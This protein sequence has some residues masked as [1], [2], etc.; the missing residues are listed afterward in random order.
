MVTQPVSGGSVVRV[1]KC[2]K[3][4]LTQCLFLSQT[5]LGDALVVF[6]YKGQLRCVPLRNLRIPSAAALLKDSDKSGGRGSPGMHERVF[7]ILSPC[8]PSAGL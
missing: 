8:S 6:L 1:W 4:S 3:K 5:G 2:P 7:S